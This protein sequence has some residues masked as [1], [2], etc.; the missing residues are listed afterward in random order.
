M[1]DERDFD[2]TRV[3]EQLAAIGRIDDFFEA[4]DAD[5]VQR[6]AS[7]MKKAGIDAPTIAMVI[8]KM[9]N[10]DGDH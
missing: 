1:M 10:A 5:N 2:G 9:E 7:L 8:H 4:I 3:L 6:A